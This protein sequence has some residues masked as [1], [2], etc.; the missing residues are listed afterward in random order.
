MVEH[1]SH[2][3]KEHINIGYDEIDWIWDDI[4][5]YMKVVNKI[6]WHT[7]NKQLSMIDNKKNN[8]DKVR[9]TDN[10]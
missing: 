7:M 3:N 8:D 2:I 6:Q 1:S 9:L 4:Y 5:I 10:I